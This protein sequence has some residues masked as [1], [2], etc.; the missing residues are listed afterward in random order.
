MENG[1]EGGGVEWDEEEGAIEVA[2][3]GSAGGEVEC[4]GEERVVEA[5][6]EWW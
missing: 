5:V 1:S 3:N 4:S 6:G 2:E